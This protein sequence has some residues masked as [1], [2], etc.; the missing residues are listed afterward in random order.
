MHILFLLKNIWGSG[1]GRVTCTLANHW[2]EK[3]WRVTLLTYAGEENDEFELHPA[4][5]RLFLTSA[6][7]A[8]GMH[9]GIGRNALRVISLR[10]ILRREK[11]DVVIGLTSMPSCLVALAG[12]PHGGLTI[13]TERVHPPFDPL[14]SISNTVRRLGYGKLDAVVAQTPESAEWIRR[15]TTAR[16]VPVILNPVVIPVPD[17]TPRLDPSRIL[18]ASGKT[19]LA[20]GRLHAQKGFDRLVR[21]F[22]R[23]APAHPDW[24]LLIAGKGHLQ[25]EL[26][27]LAAKLGVGDRVLMPGRIGNMGD[28]YEAADAFVLTSVFEGFPNVLCEAMGYGLP[29]VS[30]D[31]DTGPRDMIADGVNGLLVKQ[32]DPDALAAALSRLMG[33]PALRQR[34]GENARAIK[35]RLSLERIAGEWEALFA[36]LRRLTPA[37]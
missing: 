37:S 18:D 27:S 34:L 21:A 12:H 6:D 19:L 31:C 14:G 24:R 9:G 17:S 26:E 10:R 30:V 36:E 7:A 11:P 28:W 8:D 1:P 2:A 35:D 29:V 3:G 16:H 4:V 25:P 22:A 23:V 5:R 15:N 20:A 13:G 33:D 32:D